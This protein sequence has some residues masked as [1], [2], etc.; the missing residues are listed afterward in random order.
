[1]RI[2]IPLNVLTFIFI[3]LPI[4]VMQIVHNTYKFDGS[5][6]SMQILIWASSR[7]LKTVIRPIDSVDWGYSKPVS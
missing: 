5:S 1:M 4:L 2:V 3:Y 7:W 6:L